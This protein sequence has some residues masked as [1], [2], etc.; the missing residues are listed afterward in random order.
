MTRASVFAQTVRKLGVTVLSVLIPTLLTL[1]LAPRMSHSQDLL[2]VA[3]VLLVTRYEGSIPGICVAI[4][5]VVVFDWCFDRTPGMFAF[6][7]GNEI[8]M[9]VFVSLS[10]MIAL[11]DRQRRYALQ[12]LAATNESLRKALGEIRILQGILPICSY[13]KK[14]QSGAETWV[15]LENYVRKHSETEFSHGI[16]PDCLR[17]FYPEKTVQQ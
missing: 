7:A 15:E 11:L 1:F 2:F 16:C 10:L 6:S 12:R 9:V 14:I 5:S 4:I 3:A 13:C 17:K 8:R